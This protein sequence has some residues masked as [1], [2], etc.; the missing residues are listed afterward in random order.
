MMHVSV[1]V[2]ISQL[3]FAYKIYIYAVDMVVSAHVLVRFF[4][5][6][7][8]PAI[9]RM[10]VLPGTKQKTNG[11]CKKKNSCRNGRR[12]VHVNYEMHK[13]IPTCVKISLACKVNTFPNNIEE[14]FISVVTNLI[15]KYHINSFKEVFWTLYVHIFGI[16]RGTLV[17]CVTKVIQRGEGLKWQFALGEWIKVERYPC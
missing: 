12:P 14:F 11:E 10:S 13:H 6:Y 8:S 5:T 16:T 9:G 4:H 15:P 2:D 1:R 17:K 3:F 7:I